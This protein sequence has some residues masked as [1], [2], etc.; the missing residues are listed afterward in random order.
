VKIFLISCFGLLLSFETINAH[1][2]QTYS[3]PCPKIPNAFVIGGTISQNGVDWGIASDSIANNTQVV[4]S[5]GDLPATY[6]GGQTAGGVTSGTILQCNASFTTDR[7]YHEM[8]VQIQGI[9]SISPGRGG[10]SPA[11]HPLAQ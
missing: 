5:K 4:I 3:F 7:T 8:Y 6:N 2:D 10:Q 1:A 9:L 11:N